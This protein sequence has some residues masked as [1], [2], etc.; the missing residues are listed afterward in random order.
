MSKPN[1]GRAPKTV[2]LKLPLLEG[3]ARMPPLA[4]WKPLGLI[5]VVEPLM[6]VCST[7]A[8][9]ASLQKPSSVNQR[10]SQEMRAPICGPKNWFN[11]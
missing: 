1:S 6:S 5:R 7:V 3:K 2:R 8:P 9:R 11:V 10:S 4:V